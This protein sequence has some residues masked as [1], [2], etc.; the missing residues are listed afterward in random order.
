MARIDVIDRRADKGEKNNLQRPSIGPIE[1][2]PHGLAWLIENGDEI[3]EPLHACY[4]GSLTP[5]FGCRSE[6][7]AGCRWR[8]NRSQTRHDRRHLHRTTVILPLAETR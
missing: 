3:L 4:Y 8:R 5:E 1:D 6:F 7:R 2:A